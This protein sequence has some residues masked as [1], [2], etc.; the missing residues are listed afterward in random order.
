MED[1]IVLSGEER[2]T[3]KVLLSEMKELDI[4]EKKIILSHVTNLV[5]EEDETKIFEKEKSSQLEGL[6]TE[7]EKLN[8][9][10][11][12][13]L[14]EILKN[15][16]KRQRAKTLSAVIDKAREKKFISTQQNTE[17]EALKFAEGNSWN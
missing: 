13:L 9:N 6:M 5:N 16:S 7:V 2:A 4:E 17:D 1:I 3:L 12:I 15:N 14:D 10:Q 8:Q 11:L